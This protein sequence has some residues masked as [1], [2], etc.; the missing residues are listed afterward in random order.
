MAKHSKPGNRLTQ[1]RKGNPAIAEHGKA[2]RF[3]PGQSGNP[4]GRPRDVVSQVMRE[5]LP[6][7]CPLDK[8]G[9]AWAE[10]I[11]V[12]VFKKAVSGDVRAVSEVLD[13]TEG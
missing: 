11:A 8:N 13:R 12:A 4:S 6:T 2:T 5:L 7:P 9:L 1:A 3:Q 10:A